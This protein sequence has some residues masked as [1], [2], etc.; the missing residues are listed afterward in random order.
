LAFVPLLSTCSGAPME[1]H[2]LLSAMVVVAA[3]LA[4]SIP[5]GLMIARSVGVDVREVGSGNIG[6]TNVTR[7]VGKKLGALVLL[8]D[9]GKGALPV[10]GALLLAR[11]GIAHPV[12]VAASALAAVA[13]HCFP[14]WL[15]FKGGKG[16]ATSLGVFIVL[17]PLATGICV[18]VFVLVMLLSRVASVGSLAASLAFVATLQLRGRGAEEVALASVI[19]A[20]IWVRHIDNIKRLFRGKEHAVDAPSDRSSE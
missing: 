20:I 14:V 4:G 18:V 5:F 15:K 2:A 19:V 6:A 16:V 9:A 17:D 10:L 7:A 8:L 1:P 12:V 13:G 3:Y 11:A